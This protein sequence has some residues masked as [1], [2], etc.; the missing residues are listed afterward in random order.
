MSEELV[1]FDRQDSVAVLT[2]NEP[3]RMNPIGDVV[4]LRLIEFLDEIS[5]NKDIRAVIITGAG[6]QFSAGAD[7]KQM[8][9]PTGGPDPLRSKRRLKV[10]HEVVRA[11]AVSPKPVVA[12]VEGVA[13]GAGLSVVAAS[14][15]VIAGKTAR[16]GA[17]FGRIGLAPDCG[18]MWSLPQRIGLARTKDLIFTGKPLSAQTAQQ[19]GLVDELVEEGAALERA[20][21][22]VQEYM[23]VAPLS[24]AATKEAAAALPGSL[25]AALAIETHQQPLLSM[26]HDHSE[27]RAAFLEKR[28]PNFS[29][30]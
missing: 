8:S 25:E 26:S 30:Q 2:L 11:I 10:L 15:F 22:K 6:G 23:N 12:A 27:A 9:A 4:R 17:A 16:L 13:F 19:Y 29:G 21:E 1:L 7:V 20:L 18:L 24:I 3:E 14:D 28:P 5:A